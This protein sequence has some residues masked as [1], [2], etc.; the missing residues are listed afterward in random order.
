MGFAIICMG[1]DL[2]RL[3][4][5][6][7]VLLGIVLTSASLILSRRA[8][9]AN[10]Q[11]LVDVAQE[12]IRENDRW[13]EG[14]PTTETRTT[15][16]SPLSRLVDSQNELHR[17][18]ARAQKNLQNEFEQ[19]LTILNSMDEGVIAIDSD[20]TILMANT[21]SKKMIRFVTDDA[22]G[23]PFIEASRNWALCNSLRKCL[24]T[25]RVQESE[26]QTVSGPLRTY[27]LRVSCL[28]G[29]PPPGAVAVLHDVTELRRLENL[30][31]EFVTNVSHELK[32]PLASI[33]AYAE[34][35]RC[36]AIHDQENNVGFV[37]RIEEQAERLHQLI[38]DMLQIARVET[39]QETMQIV[40]LSLASAARGTVA[41]HADAASRKEINVHVEC[42]EDATIQA[43]EDGLN[44]VLDNLVSNAI[45]YTPVG[46]KIV[47]AVRKTD[48]EAILEV[49]DNGIGIAPENQPRV[50]E[51]FFRADKARSRAVI[52]TGLGL[53]IV[54]HLTQAFGGSVAVSSE[55]GNGSTF[56]LR[57][58]LPETPPQ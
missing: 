35:L 27:A 29:N 32:T 47:V 43:D 8:I 34:T 44:T 52:S 55:L 25:G 13:Q 9:Q 17:V 49:S 20:E 30:R 37:Q 2:H 22:R 19:L 11:P 46:G 24:S 36:G 23:R 41:Q 54:K 1:L 5:F 40:E 28:P 15:L 56:T 38:Q 45:K 58:P 51:R 12:L 7:V 50:F 21:A 18:A 6:G 53:S 42:S 14:K 48:D 4:S 33:L 57:F 26:I 3:N 10:L 31:H 39:G 16:D